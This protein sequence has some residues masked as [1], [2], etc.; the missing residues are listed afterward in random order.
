MP[1]LPTDEADAISDMI[2]LSEAIANLSAARLN[3]GNSLNMASTSEG[4]AN[5]LLIDTELRETIAAYRVIRTRFAT[6]KGEFR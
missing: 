3:L 6:P 2:G 4:R 5:L 1:N